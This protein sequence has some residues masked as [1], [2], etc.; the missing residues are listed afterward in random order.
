VRSSRRA[1]AIS[2]VIPSYNHSAFLEQTIDSVRSQ[3]LA[4]DE[5]VVVDDGSSDGSRELLERLRYNEMRLELQDNRGAHHAINR[6]IELS[7]GEYVAI[8]NSDDVFEH[9][10]IEHAWGVARATGAALLCGEVRL[11]GDDG[12]EPP[13]DHE[14][15]RWYAEAR[16]LGR[17]APSLAHAL[18]RHNVGVTTSNFFLHRAL[19]AQLGGFRAYRYVHDY[20]FILRAMAL[21]PG[22][23]VYEPSLCDVRYRVHGANTISE[24]HERAMAERAGML[25]TVHSPVARVRGAVD[26]LRRSPAV[27]RAVD[28][29][30]MLDPIRP[31]ST[32]STSSRIRTDTGA[33]PG[34]AADQ[35]DSSAELKVGL[36]VTSLGTGGLEEVVAML[37]QSLPMEGLGVAVYCTEAGGPVAHRLE[38]AGVSVTVGSAGQ[39]GCGTWA[40]EA[41]ID[42]VS[43]HFVSVDAVRE[44]AEQGIPVVETVHNS[45]AW[46]SDGEW[47]AERRR[48]ALV[49]G[50]VAV[51]DIAAEYYAART[52]RAPDV[53]IPNAVHPARAAAVPRAFAR[54]HLGID[55]TGPVFVSVGRLTR[56]KNVSG[57]LSAFA[58]VC[59]E[60]SD[61]QLVLVGPSDASEP[62]GALRSAHRPLLDSGAV[63]WLGESADVGVALSAADA[64]VSNSWYEGWSVAA[65]EAAWLGLPLVLSDA[66][67]ATSMVGVERGTVE[68]RGARAGVRGFVVPNPGGD[69]LLVD[70][71]SITSSEP[72]AR[73]ANESALAASL[74]AIADDLEGWRERSDEIA[75]WARRT[76]APS[77]MATAHARVLRAAVQPSGRN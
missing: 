58:S 11:I 1:G 59:R 70:E 9:E 43:S 19:W 5:L 48:A 36:L 71:A 7:R 4:P 22:R 53:V 45:Y 51:S 27:R 47:A 30:G 14:I 77:A 16:T 38:S 33:A 44:V 23:V 28:D 68:V 24:A 31:E 52:G 63:R 73:T 50:L 34:Q 2:V 66:G 49:Q 6:A 54:R 13:S 41:G 76:L 32:R 62:W 21:C 29:T 57:L 35:G 65:S 18:R 10:R 39:V 67:G 60:V 72:S 56:Q 74:T 3:T 61:A 17:T 75:D 20:D 26:R 46:L 55:T 64:F 42:V 37:A 15:T 8:L 69:P 12:G 25:R 40:V